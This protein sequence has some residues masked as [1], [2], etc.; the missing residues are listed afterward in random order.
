LLDRDGYAAATR[1]K[2]RYAFATQ[3]IGGSQGIATVMEAV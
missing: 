3:C 2:G 1:T